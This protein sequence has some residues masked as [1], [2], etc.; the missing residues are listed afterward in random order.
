M[1]LARGAGGKLG[2]RAQV[3]GQSVAPVVNVEVVVHEAATDGETRVEQ[4]SP[5]RIE[6]F[7]ARQMDSAIRGGKLHRTMKAVYGLTP[8]PM[9]A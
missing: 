7:L 8:K 6:V 5:G 9:G 1:P 4:S 2:V 3:S